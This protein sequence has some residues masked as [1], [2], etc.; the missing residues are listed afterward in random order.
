MP[1]IAAIT[2]TFILQMGV[3]YLPFANKIFKTN[4]LT[5]NELLIS[6]AAAAV[7]FHAVEIEKLVKRII[8]KKNK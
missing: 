3:I 2:L 4:P 7:V 5:I 6:L 8:S 1:L